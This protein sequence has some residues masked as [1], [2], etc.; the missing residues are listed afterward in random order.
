MGKIEILQGLVIGTN[1]LQCKGRIIN[2]WKNSVD[3]CGVQVPLNDI[4]VG[5]LKSEYGPQL[6]KITISDAG[7]D[8]ELTSSSWRA[9]LFFAVD[10]PLLNFHTR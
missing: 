7:N 1:Q 4:L 9:N 6:R 8:L 2:Y 3:K 5:E 10:I